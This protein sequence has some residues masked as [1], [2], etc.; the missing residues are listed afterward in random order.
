MLCLIK[1][2]KINLFTVKNVQQLKKLYAWGHKKD[3]FFKSHEHS[4]LA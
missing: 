3:F 4:H 2:H 1:Q